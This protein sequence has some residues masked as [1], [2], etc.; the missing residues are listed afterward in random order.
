[1]TASAGLE[2]LRLVVTGAA[3]GV[4]AAVM[5]HFAAQGAFVAGID[6][7]EPGPAARAGGGEDALWVQADLARREGRRVAGAALDRWTDG[8]DLLV[9][10]AGSFAPDPPSDE[11]DSAGEV[12]ERL[13]ADNV[14]TAACLSLSLFPLLCRGRRPLV[15]HIAST[16]AVVASGGQSCEVGVRHDVLYAATK[17][18][19]LTLTRGLAMKWA[20]AGIRVDA[21]CPTLVRTPM[22]ADLLRIPGKEDELRAHLP[23]GRICEPEDVAVAVECLYR[24]G[25]TTAHVLPLDGGYLCR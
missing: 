1:M 13:W 9:H 18:A 2:G 10:A 12:L 24:L 4:G 23:L 25:M 16:D 21:V 22:A 3:G 7:Q 19:L 6:R 15:V 20:E 14:Q 5:R 11:P 17:G 8:I